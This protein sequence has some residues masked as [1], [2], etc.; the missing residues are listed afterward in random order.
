MEIFDLY[1]ADRE[2]TGRTMVRGT[3]TPEG[4]YRLGFARSQEQYVRGYERL[5]EALD[6]LDAHLEKR[7]FSGSLSQARS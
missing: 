6:F 3:P 5:F 4:F 1:T 7:R 2:K